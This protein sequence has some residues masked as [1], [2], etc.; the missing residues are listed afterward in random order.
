MS[1]SC[2]KGRSAGPEVYAP[3]GANRRSSCSIPG[4]CV[5]SG[6]AEPGIC[7][8]KSWIGSPLLL[9]TLGAV[10]AD[11]LLQRRPVLEP[12]LIETLAQLALSR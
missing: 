1:V 5:A 8:I 6:A 12:D 3:H 2:G 4:F 10:V 11:L 7:Q 9:V